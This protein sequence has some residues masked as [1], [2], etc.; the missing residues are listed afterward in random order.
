MPGPNLAECT[1]D[2]G[3]VVQIKDTWS[4]NRTSWENVGNMKNGKCEIGE[5]KW[6][7]GFPGVCWKENAKYVHYC[8]LNDTFNP[9]QA[10]YGYKG[11]TDSEFDNY[12]VSENVCDS[13]CKT[14][15]GR[16]Y[17]YANS[18]PK[19]VAYWLDY[20]K[21]TCECKKNK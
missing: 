16:N 19:E 2:K 6:P 21:T 13:M 14:K 10:K 12:S 4:Y 11:S 17:S 1:N 9:F 3:E 8:R 18:Y 15:L 20:K 5:E 7:K